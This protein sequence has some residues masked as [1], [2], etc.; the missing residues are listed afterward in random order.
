MFTARRIQPKR[1][2]AIF[3]RE[4]HQG[5]ASV[6]TAVEVSDSMVFLRCSVC[7]NVLPASDDASVNRY[8]SRCRG[9]THMPKLDAASWDYA[10]VTPLHAAL[11]RTAPVEV[12]LQVRAA[13]P[14]VLV[15]AEPRCSCSDTEPTR[16][17]KLSAGKHRCTLL[18]RVAGRTYARFCWLTEATRTLPPQ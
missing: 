8:C 1:P 11:T 18:L 9:V 12:A 15:A 16:M 2:S 3:S 5:G 6:V 4:L 10:G 14:A 17:R 7:A 13:F